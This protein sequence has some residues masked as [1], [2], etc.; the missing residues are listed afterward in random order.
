MHKP[1]SLAALQPPPCPPSLPPP[2]APQLLIS[3]PATGAT[4]NSFSSLPKPPLHFSS[5]SPTATRSPAHH[6]PPIPPT[7]PP[8]PSPQLSTPHSPA[9]LAGGSLAKVRGYRK[10][11]VMVSAIYK[12]ARE[13]NRSSNESHTGAN[14]VRISGWIRP[15][16]PGE[17]RC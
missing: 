12:W 8:P 4:H 6:H 15:G 5:P 17:L 9:T 1:D 7:T 16:S 3:R 14:E 13:G 2:R 10:L 11:D